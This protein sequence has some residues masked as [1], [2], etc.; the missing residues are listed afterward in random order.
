MLIIGITGSFGTGKTTVCQMFR[1]LGAEVI[2]ADK[3]A[4]NILEKSDIKDKLAKIFNLSPNQSP[5]QFRFQIAKIIFRNKEGRKK[6]ERII[7]PLIIT[8][9]KKELSLSKKEIT[10]IDAPLLLETELCEIVHKIIVV[11][12]SL[13]KQI[14]R[15]QKKG[16]LKEEILERINC[17]IPLSQKLEQADFIINNDGIKE[18]KRQVKQIWE[19]LV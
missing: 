6:V 3:I 18:T 13:E 16:F 19:V 10:I 15:G 14:S 8:E 4:H 12:A 7:H 17:Q 5:R 11:T 9:I 2:D 1:K